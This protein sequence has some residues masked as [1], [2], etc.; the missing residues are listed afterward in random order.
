VEHV[1]LHAPDQLEFDFLG[2]DSMRYHNTVTVPT[3]IF[4]CFK[5]FSEGKKEDDEIF[6]RLTVRYFG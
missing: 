3:R 6:D 4:A 5:K 2:K 1:K